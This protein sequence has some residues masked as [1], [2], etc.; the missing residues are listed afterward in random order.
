MAASFP[1][2][3]SYQKPA[4]NTNKDPTDGRS[5]M[6]AN[7][8]LFSCVT[9][10][11]AQNGRLFPSLVFLGRARDGGRWHPST[12]GSVQFRRWKYFRNSESRLSSGVLL[13]WYHGLRAQPVSFRTTEG[14]WSRQTSSLHSLLPTRFSVWPLPTPSTQ[15]FRKSSRRRM[16][17]KLAHHPSKPQNGTP[18]TITD[19]PSPSPTSIPPISPFGISRS[20]R[21]LPLLFSTP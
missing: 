18:W 13:P 3:T 7:S 8:I 2:L 6:F 20:K 19:K 12:Q 14:D 9:G 15:S 5:A 16:R 10:R 21:A 4:Q 1:S 11:V 17:R